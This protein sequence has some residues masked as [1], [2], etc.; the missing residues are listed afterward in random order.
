MS[1]AE[2]LA[3]TKLHRV[4][5]PP[6][7]GKTTYLS[8]QALLAAAKWGGQNL[9]VA[10]LT[11][12]AAAEVAGRD[13][14]IPPANVGTLHAHAYRALGYP[15]LAETKKGYE[16]W[17]ERVPQH[18]RILA[19]A[20]DPEWSNPEDGSGGKTDGERML[21][22][23]GVLRAT[24]TPREKW[25]GQARAFADRW[26]EWKRETNRLDFTD[27][28]ERGATI[29][30]PLHPAVVFLDE[31]QDMSALEMA[32]AL[33]WAA[34]AEQ[35]VIVGDAD[36]C[37]PRGTLVRT[38]LHG[39]V[40]IEQLDPE[41]H[42]LRSFDTRGSTIVTAK[43]FAVTS[44]PFTGALLTVDAGGRSTDA[45]PDHRWSVQWTAEA[46]ERCCVYLMRRGEHWRV[47]WCQL[48]GAVGFHLGARARLD[49]A[50]EAWILSTHRDRREASIAETLIAVRYGLPLPTFREADVYAA[51]TP[52]DVRSVEQRAIDC[53]EEHGR[54]YG[55]PIW[56]KAE[57][58]VKQGR[59]TSWHVRTCNLI[60]ELMALP[61][62]R[63]DGRTCSWE[64]ITRCGYR[65]PG[66]MQ[67]YSLNVE[68]HHTYVA[69]G[70]VT[71]NCLFEWRG[72]SQAAFLG[73]AAAS[74]HV[75]SQSY[76]VPRAVHAYA[77]DWVQ[78]I[79]ERP[80]VAYLPRP[81]E[82]SIETLHSTY[83]DPR[84]LVDEV[85]RKPEGETAMILASCAYM[86]D[87]AI[88][89]LRE[90]GVPFHNPYRR[91]AGRWNPLASANRPLAFLRP[92]PEQSG[93]EGRLWTFDELRLWIEPLAGAGWL[94]RGTKEDVKQLC[95]T[96]RKDEPVPMDYFVDMLKGDDHAEARRLIVH[97]D[98]WLALRW[99]ASK[100]RPKEQ[101]RFAYP[102]QIAERYGPAKLRE[103]PT[104]VVGTIH[105][106]KGGEA[107][108]VAVFPD[109]SL[110]A[111]A[112]EDGRGGW[113]HG[114]P[115]QYPLVRLFYVAFTRARTRLLLCQ[116]TSNLTVELPA[117]NPPNGGAR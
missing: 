106:V 14:G 49:G 13:T 56:S 6:G 50:D 1:V 71:R 65:G 105:S 47:G 107:D 41:V 34:S 5:G 80:D 42:E 22:A 36:Q 52:R 112:G 103:T 48:F 109:L 25:G 74:E 111:W 45:T 33:H 17:N 110:A 73:P 32:L 61:I 11:K 104:V 76:R 77:V 75:L 54:A 84:L 99:W 81:A 21:A 69:D 100:L 31:A 67:V 63:P 4:H 58:L 87:P 46:R 15:E 97:D 37:Q 72:S 24:L 117:P 86:L 12:A 8:R 27:L 68:P 60:P 16:D 88:K 9:I 35:T 64:P 30:H 39:D 51:L 116:P 10:S 44:R 55:L 108:T 82:G 92:H 53:L 114:G 20:R 95:A 57:R 89:L 93:G 83:L 43:R 29:P 28:I 19:P 2:T 18:L 7:C 102:L 101:A 90:R 66:S 79:R 91:T 40:P 85:E 94:A 98:P 59:R 96:G 3:T 113:A 115:A 26:D 62:P 70:I 23:V 78:Q 38:R